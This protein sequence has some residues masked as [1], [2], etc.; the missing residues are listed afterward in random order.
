MIKEL[1]K[2]V[3]VAV[4]DILIEVDWMMVKMNIKVVCMEK[5]V[6]DAV[7]FVNLHSEQL[8]FVL[9][10]TRSV[11]ERYFRPSSS[12]ILFSGNDIVGV[13]SYISGVEKTAPT[14]FL[15]F[16]VEKPDYINDILKFAVRKAVANEKLFI[17][18]LIYGYE[19]EIITSLKNL[20]FKVAAEIPDMVSYDGELYPMVILYLDLRDRYKFNVARSY[21]SEELYPLRKV[22]KAREYSFKV[23]GLKY[24]DLDVFEKVFNEP[25]VFRTM[26][27]GIFEGL[28]Y[29][30]KQQIWESLLKR[31]F[32]TLTCI[33][34]K[35]EVP[36]GFLSLDPYDQDVLKSVGGIGMFVDE[37]YHGLGV[38]SLL[39]ENALLL[40]KR[41]H[42]RMLYLSVF[43][44]N[45]A[46][47]KLYK[48]FG[49]IE[50]GKFPGWLQNGY[51]NEIFMSR[52]L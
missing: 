35:K 11:V 14:G 47:I 37:K 13:F 21:V 45:I 18:T 48:K 8:G 7:D 32:Y 9:P 20:G 25:N 51:I 46:G 12:Y 6:D 10:V 31:E 2:K 38:G 42:L 24:E 34:E 29:V 26:G 50:H 1:H 28:V 33:D 41:L 40:G 27:R 16:I 4:N 17:R 5:F 39:M 22:D 44:T 49:F 52:K 36:V 43:D 19:K 3:Y 30:N 15:R 23:R